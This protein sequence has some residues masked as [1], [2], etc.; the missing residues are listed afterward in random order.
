MSPIEQKPDG[1]LIATGPGVKVY[2]FVAVL[3]VVAH[4]AKYPNGPQLTRIVPTVA[5][6]KAA[7]HLP[8]NTRTYKQVAAILNKRWEQFLQAPEYLTEEQ[9]LEILLYGALKTTK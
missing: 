6:L 5:K 3:K 4:R 8:D 9:R 7:Y 2:A 1:T